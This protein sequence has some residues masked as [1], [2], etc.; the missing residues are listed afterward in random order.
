MSGISKLETMDV[1]GVRRAILRR[2]RFILASI[3]VFGL[4]GLAIN[5]LTPPLYRA[6]A[7]LEVR[8]PA[9]HS[10]WTGQSLGSTNYQSENVQLYTNVELM[11]NRVL[12]ARLAGDLNAPGSV[13]S[14]REP[15]AWLPKWLRVPMARASGRVPAENAAFGSNPQRVEQQVDWLQNRIRVQ[16]VR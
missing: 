7:R 10:A 1:P 11:T 8:K 2:K 15:V 4:L 5:V 14:D 3:A 12:L 13:L 16:P 6:T 9:D